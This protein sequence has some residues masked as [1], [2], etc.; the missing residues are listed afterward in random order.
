M[1]LFPKEAYLILSQAHIIDWGIKW[2]GNIKQVMFL[3]AV[4]SYFYQPRSGRS[5]W[6]VGSEEEEEEE[7]EEEGDDFCYWRYSFASKVLIITI[8]GCFDTFGN[9]DHSILILSRLHWPFL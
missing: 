5:Y 7:E 6:G 4:C 2:R 8:S 3:R 9:F 1:S